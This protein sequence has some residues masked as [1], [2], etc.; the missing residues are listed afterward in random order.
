MRKWRVWKGNNQV[1]VEHDNKT[2][3][4]RLGEMQLNVPSCTAEIEEIFE[5]KG[6][7]PPERPAAPKLKL[8][9]NRS[10]N[11]PNTNIDT[12]DDLFVLDSSDDDIGDFFG[13]NG[14]WPYSR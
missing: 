13:F 8:N 4:A 3:A 9:L 10:Y 7:T 14:N 1:I 2:E 6:F 5:S 12:D 11:S